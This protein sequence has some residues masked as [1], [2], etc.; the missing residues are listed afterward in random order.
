MAKPTDTKPASA[1]TEQV[2]TSAPPAPAKQ[3]A[4]PALDAREAAEV[5]EAADD[6]A[7]RAEAVAA[8]LAASK[9]GLIQHPEA[10]APAPPIAAKPTAGT[11]KVWAHGTLQRNG[12]TYQPGDTLTLDA[13]EADKIP[14]LELVA[15]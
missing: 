13:A 3:E 12:K 15:S 14:C 9:P 7:K 2:S 5:A 1:E 10:P 6:R 11:Y 8:K 4:K